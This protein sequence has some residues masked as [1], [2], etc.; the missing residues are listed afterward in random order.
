MRQ[1]RKDHRCFR[2]ALADGRAGAGARLVEARL[3]LADDVV[4]RLRAEPVLAQHALGGE[5]RARMR[6]EEQRRVALRLA[7]ERVGALHHCQLG[8]QLTH[9][10]HHVQ[11]VEACAR[12][13]VIGY[14][15]RIAVE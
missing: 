6:E 15:D 11:R 12:G 1:R 8:Q 5:H 9:L 14:S 3:D 13:R 7:A 10:G 2:A 4:E